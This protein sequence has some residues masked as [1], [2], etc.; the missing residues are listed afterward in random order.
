MKP[1]ETP[2]WIAFAVFRG[3]ILYWLGRYAATSFTVLG[4]IGRLIS[5]ALATGI[6]LRRSHTSRRRLQGTF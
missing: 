3:A 1:L 6:V 2:H 5:A 4:M